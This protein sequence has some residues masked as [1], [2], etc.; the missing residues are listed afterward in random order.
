MGYGMGLTRLAGMQGFRDGQDRQFALEDRERK[1][2]REDKLG[3]RQDKMFEREDQAFDESEARK[4]AQKFMQR[5]VMSDG[6]DVSGFDDMYTKVPDGYSSTTSRNEDGTYSVQVR[7]EKDGSAAEPIKLTRDQLAEVGNRLATDPE[8]WANARAASDAS[9]AKMQ[10]EYA[11]KANDQAIK[12]DY[13][14]K[15][16][17]VKSGGITARDSAKGASDYAYGA[18]M[19]ALKHKNNLAIKGVEARN[20]PRKAD[21]D[22]LKPGEFRTRSGKPESV[23]NAERLMRSEIKVPDEFSIMMMES[24]GDPGKQKLAAEYRRRLMEA[25]TLRDFIKVK[26]GADVYD[27]QP[28]QAPPPGT[29]GYSHLWGGK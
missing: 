27:E 12:Y 3:A 19:E 24:S 29:K 16:E 7:N 15:L 9:Y 21:E 22:G 11:N 1:I 26:F 23:V 6:Q 20:N 18:K 8:A 28:V 5:F 2:A 13:D 4:S 17:G 10:T 25:G 14:A